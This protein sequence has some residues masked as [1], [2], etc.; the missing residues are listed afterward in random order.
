[1][2]STAGWA[3]LP[4]CASASHATVVVAARLHIACICHFIC[5]YCMHL[6]NACMQM[7]A[8]SLHAFATSVQYL[9]S[10]HRYQYL[11]NIAQKW[12]MHR[13]GKCKA[14]CMLRAASCAAEALNAGRCDSCNG[15]KGSGSV[16]IGTLSCCFFWVW[17]AQKPHLFLVHFCIMSAPVAR[18]Q[19]L[20]CVQLGAP[21]GCVQLGGLQSRR[22][23]I[24]LLASQCSHSA[25]GFNSQVA[26]LLASQSPHTAAV[27]SSLVEL[28]AQR[29]E[30]SHRRMSVTGRSSET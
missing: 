23:A 20:G 3:D 10:I 21:L 24:A 25:G 7:H 11:S 12:Q 27:P 16:A 18:A 26:L 19:P 2:S 29:A 13:S 8:G 5:H 1:M 28:C 15:N 17:Q 14:V 9:S 22:R 4:S 6:A 30:C